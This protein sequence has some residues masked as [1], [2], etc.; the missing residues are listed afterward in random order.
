MRKVG[1]DIEHWATAFV[2]E[3]ILWGRRLVMAEALK[4]YIE[5]GT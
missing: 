3:R 2:G 1:S 5:K 4:W